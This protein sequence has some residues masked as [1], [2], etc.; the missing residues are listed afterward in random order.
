L[1]LSLP[2]ARHSG[3]C[4]A[5]DY[6]LADPG[7]ATQAGAVSMAAMSERSFRRRFV[8]E[9]GMNWQD[10]LGQARILTAMTLLGSGSRVTDVAADVGYASLSAFAKP[11]SRPWRRQSSYFKR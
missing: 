11:G 3:I 1:P 2:T 6:A 10:W 8:A 4:R 5:I 9:T 7:R